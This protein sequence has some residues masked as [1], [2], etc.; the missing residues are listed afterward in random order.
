MNIKFDI[1]D[2]YEF[3]LLRKNLKIITIT[4]L[5]AAIFLV[6]YALALPN[7]YQ[8]EAV[9]AP[10]E[11]DL[12]TQLNAINF[13]R[14][15]D[16][17]ALGN[18]S[19]GIVLEKDKT[20]ATLN[21]ISFLEDFLDD[22]ILIGFFAAKKYNPKTK[23]LEINNK[24][25][26]IKESKWVRK[27]SSRYQTK[28]TAQEFYENYIEQVSITENKRTGLITIKYEH[29]SPYF[30]KLFVESLVNSLNKY[31]S[32]QVKEETEKFISYL[33]LEIAENNLREIDS[34]FN[35]L[36]QKNIEKM[37]YAEAKQDFALKYIAYPIAPE[38][39]S[40][41][42]RA[43]ICIFGFISFQIILFAYLIFLYIKQKIANEK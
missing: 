4:S 14:A 40:S 32:N 31:R 18:G 9:L 26:D 29:I 10:V 15:L 11:Q 17:G 25:Y 7:K 37:M 2:F 12:E 30:S 24:I 22:D 23:E 6:I 27:T 28:P 43:L 33:E 19:T 16:F 34:A 41:P 1:N 36:L 39:K 21:S 3:I 20:L 38:F 42:S 35:S 8:S 13:S 5:L